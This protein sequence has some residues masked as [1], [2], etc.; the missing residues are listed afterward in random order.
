MKFRIIKL[1]AMDRKLMAKVF[2][3]WFLYVLLMILFYAV[4]CTLPFIKW[5]PM[6]LIPLAVAVSMFESECSSAIFGCICGFM[7]DLAGGGLFGFTSIWLMPCCLMVTLLIVNL[8]HQNIFNFLWMSLAACIIVNLME[9]FFKYVIWRQEHVEIVITNY[10]L[11][12]VIAGMI[13]SP[14]IYLIVRKISTKLGYERTEQ[15]LVNS[16]EEN[17]NK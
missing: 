1:G 17:A 15:D 11:P 9:V 5:Q 2:F 13:I 10:M 16:F 6:L 4:Q 3:R 14:L 8:I 12:S 7:I